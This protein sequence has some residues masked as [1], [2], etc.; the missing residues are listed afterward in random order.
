VSPTLFAHPEW[1]AALVCLWLAAGL[2]LAAAETVARRRRRRLGVGIPAA[3]R[4]LDSDLALWLALGSLALALA[5]PRLGERLL[6]LP[7]SGVDVVFVVDV[8][9]SMDA[10]D[11]A[12]SRLARARR[13]VEELLARLD[14]ADR[15]ALAAFAGR[16][17]LLTPL[18][19]DRDVIAE[20]LAGL[21][22]ALVAPAS[23]RIDAGVRAALSAF[24]A[25]S[26][27]PR[28]VMLLGDGE[29]PE[30]RRDLGSAIAVRADAR[31]LAAGF[32][33]AIG[34]PLDDHG[35]P[36]LGESGQPVVSRRDLERLA[37]LAA[38]TDG[39]LFEA[40]AWGEIDLDAAAAEIRRDTAP[41][42]GAPGETRGA[43][44]SPAPGTTVLRRVRSVP[45]APLAALALALLL[46]EGL[47]RPRGRPRGAVPSLAGAALV[48]VAALP[49]PAGDALLSTLPALERAVRANPG[50]PQLLIDLGVARLERGQRDAAARAFLAAALSAQDAEAAAIAYF[51]LGVAALEQGDYTGARAAFLD[52]LAL[53][54]EDHRARFN[55]E[56]TLEALQQ[57][58][59]PKPSSEPAEDSEPE[60]APPPLPDPAPDA[61]PEAGSPAAEPPRLS[62]EE[63]RRWLERVRDDPRRALRAAAAAASPAERRT[64]GPAW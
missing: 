49:A 39:A 16:G 59:A 13:A 31:V 53:A 36:L 10:S 42:R 14:P 26:E 11:V 35:V 9:R 28:V 52:A 29:D 48:L 5:G 25:G 45:V 56:W 8:S 23:S 63:Q 1:L 32:G 47:P 27:R 61:P 44:G 57:H 20:L 54:P 4:R 46:V 64:G 17:V 30:R 51:D 7:A 12:P 6:E 40:D 3:A 34:S 41:A 58:P 43:A 50:D 24:E 37:R 18:T 38:E 60:P 33:T 62:D 22:T 21:D 55:L 2:A 15:F 19:P